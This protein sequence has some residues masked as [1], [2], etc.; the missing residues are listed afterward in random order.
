MQH[1]K[2]P[3]SYLP[4]NLLSSTHTEPH[5]CSTEPA[6]TGREVHRAGRDGRSAGTGEATTASV[7]GEVTG[8]RTDPGSAYLHIPDCGMPQAPLL[9]QSGGQEV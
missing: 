9:G 4:S 6:L 3:L 2:K 7:A 1:D 8:R 5:P